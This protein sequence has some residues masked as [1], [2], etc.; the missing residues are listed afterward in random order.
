MGRTDRTS[1]VKA[2]RDR[3]T[4]LLDAAVVEIAT[5]GARGL[6][7]ERVAERAGVSVALIYHYFGDRSTLLRTALEHVG[8]RARRYTSPPAGATGRVRLTAALLDEIQDD[9]DV[10]T[11]SA[12]WGE[13]RDAAIFDPVL[14]PTLG[15]LTRRWID[16]IAAMIRE[17]REDGSIATGS[18][19]GE[20][21]VRL[22]ALVEGISG[23]WL[24][25]LLEADVARSH[26]AAGVAAILGQPPAE[27]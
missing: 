17:G 14:R 15:E 1:R 9:A 8:E 11:N 19:A 12:A 27:A 3:R 18:D 23:R 6:R 25:G 7:V 10:R 2:P 26:L 13:L 24:T 4:A 5:N 20:A 16:D 21:A 22:T